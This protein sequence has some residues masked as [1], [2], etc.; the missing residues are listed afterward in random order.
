[1]PIKEYYQIFSEAFLSF[2]NEQDLLNYK[3]VDN[4]KEIVQSTLLRLGIDY[5]NPT[6]EREIIRKKLN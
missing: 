6:L 5:L 3:Q 2:F 1:M 4:Y